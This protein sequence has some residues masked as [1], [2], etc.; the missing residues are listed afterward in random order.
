MQRINHQDGYSVDGARA[1]GAESC[2]SR[3]RRGELGH[4]HHIAGPSLVRTAQEAVRP[5]DPRRVSNGGQA[6]G[7]IG[8]G[9]RSGPLGAAQAIAPQAAP[10]ALTSA[11]A[12]L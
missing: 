4:R 1:N 8:L 3:L 6:H 7:I 5:E 11:R 2:F 10:R 9:M 12:G